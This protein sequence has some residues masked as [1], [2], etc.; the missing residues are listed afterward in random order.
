MEIGPLESLV[1]KY[2]QEIVRGTPELE[3]RIKGV[4]PSEFARAFGR[5]RDNEMAI[6]RKVNII[7]R[8]EPKGINL[9]REIEFIGDGKKEAVLSKSQLTKPVRA[10]GYII[11]LSAESTAKVFGAA[12]AMSVVRVKA[13]ASCLVK[14]ASFSWRMDLTVVQQITGREIIELP[15]IVNKML[16]SGEITPKNFLNLRD[17]N[18]SYEIE[19]ELAVPTDDIRAGDVQQAA[20]YLLGLM[21]RD[22]S[23]VPIGLAIKRMNR[24]IGSK[25][26]QW[27]GL[28]NIL[29]QVIT[30]SR[31][32][33]R[34][35]YPPNGYFVTDKADGYRAVA[36]TGG[37]PP[38][39]ITNMCTHAKFGKMD[40]VN[41]LDGELVTTAEKGLKFYA[42]DA[43]VV[44][45]TSLMGMNFEDRILRIEEGVALLNKAGIPA[46]AKPYY[47]ISSAEPA[48]MKEVFMNVI[49]AGRPYEVDGIIVVAP[50]HSYM[51]TVAYKW[52]DVG[53]TTFDFLV[54]KAP[55]VPLESG[56]VLYWLFV[57]IQ[58]QLCTSLGLRLCP[59]WDTLFDSAALASSARIPI[60]FSPSSA[61]LAY[62]WW[63]PTDEL[64]G[65][66]AEFKWTPGSGW[67]L[68][69]IRDDRD[70]YGNSYKTAETN[71]LNITDPF[72]LEQL[73][74]GPG[75]EYFMTEK[76]KSH[77][78]QTAVISTMKDARIQTLK[79]AN[80]VVDLG[81]GKGQDLARYMRAG[82]KNLVAVDKDT[83]ALSELVL[84][85]YRFVADKAKSFATGVHI[86]V[87]DV[88]QPAEDTIA[89]LRDYGLTEPADAVVSNLAAH[90][91]MKDT[92]TIRN[93]A[94]LARSCVRPGGQL[95]LT[96][97]LGS[98]VHKLFIDGGIAPGDTWDVFEKD[99][100]KFSIK[101]LY[102]SDLLEEAGQRI[103]VLLPFSEGEYYEEWLVNENSLAT[104]LAACGFSLSEKTTAI[105]FIAD[106]E[107][108]DGD[109]Q[110]LSLFGEL[111]WTNGAGA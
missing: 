86:L 35:I 65:K 67:S 31:G 51:N 81:T 105:D 25:G 4:T 13:R 80:W 38:I 92:L 55:T 91:F 37:G 61:P 76:S 110:W 41:V 103:G 107:V 20:T 49:S 47:R 82:V 64:D 34:G 16:K 5:L 85:K 52:K 50:G 32:V 18:Y 27:G 56:R 102:S 70:D 53:L 89:M 84:R 71:W 99:V 58:R 21:G 101:R 8:L 22:A 44:N 69:K 23:D 39:I 1:G 94:S 19:A 62:Q 77:N 17:E 3:I 88:N 60:Q 106:R 6:T 111:V 9:I 2:R 104:E 57:G 10:S 93:F 7:K 83:S 15:A 11:A 36:M 79:K 29:P 33:Y 24:L 43:M 72:P 54:R 78:A 73:W 46:E 75:S 14:L 42:F 48:A 109:R 59:G 98:A 66:I 12:D 45:G 28:K 74:D 100:R 97:M 40:E 108:T 87:A 68:V 30:L 90:Y 63:H 95:I 26:H 96:V